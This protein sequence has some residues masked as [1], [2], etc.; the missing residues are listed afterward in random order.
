ML[1]SEHRAGRA[2]W[3]CI[4]RPAEREREGE[5]ERER[6]RERRNQHVTLDGSKPNT[7]R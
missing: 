7:V 3:L 5:G 4:P 1:N 6:E 2:S